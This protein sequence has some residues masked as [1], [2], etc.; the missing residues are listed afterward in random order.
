MRDQLRMARTASET[1]MPTAYDDAFEQLASIVPELFRFLTEH[2]TGVS[3]FRPSAKQCQADPTL[4]LQTRSSPS[5]QILVTNDTYDPGL[6]WWIQDISA[7][8]TEGGV[9]YRRKTFTELFEEREPEVQASDYHRGGQRRT[10]F[11]HDTLQNTFIYSAGGV[12]GLEVVT[13]DQNLNAASNLELLLVSGVRRWIFP[14]P[15][16]RRAE[17]TD[18]SRVF[19]SGCQTL[20]KDRVECFK[21]IGIGWRHS[22]FAIIG[23]EPKQPPA[24]TVELNP[25]RIRRC[26]AERSVNRTVTELEVARSTITGSNGVGLA[27]S[28]VEAQFVTLQ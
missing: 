1:S 7:L 24:E 2:S 6:L 26:E 14:M 12:T 27:T 21:W 13:D 23:I 5:L 8:T 18:S 20:S 4:E 22:G 25:T 19:N 16:S 15:L 17:E 9:A 10:G 28:F 11:T 3:L